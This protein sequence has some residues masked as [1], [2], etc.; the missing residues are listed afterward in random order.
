VILADLPV[1]AEDERKR[2]ADTNPALTLLGLYRLRELGEA[3]AKD[4][5]ATIVSVPKDHTPVVMSAA[6]TEAS[7]HENFAKEFFGEL[8]SR[9]DGLAAPKK[10]V[11]LDKLRTKLKVSGDPALNQV[12]LDAFPALA[13]PGPK[14]PAD[15]PSK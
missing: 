12:I 11:I 2:L 13:A 1:K 8:K 7:Y 6:L 15:Q 9:F 4:Y 14:K 10:D 5:V 3:K